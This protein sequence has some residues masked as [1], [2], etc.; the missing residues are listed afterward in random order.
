MF[1]EGSLIQAS[2]TQVSSD[3]GGEVIILSLKSGIYYGLNEV[4]TTIWNLIQQPTTFEQIFKTVVE[5]YEVE[6]EQCKKDLLEILADMRKA[7]LLEVN[8][9]MV[10]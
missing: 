3:L 10:V 4:G 1:N 5:D 9:A 7:G 8:H 2:S 6:A